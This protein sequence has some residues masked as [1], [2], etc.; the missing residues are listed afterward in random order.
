MLQA[1]LIV[2]GVLTVSQHHQIGHYVHD[3]VLD[4]RYFQNG[5]AGCEQWED[6]HKPICEDYASRRPGR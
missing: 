6:R 1:F 4:Y 3:R 2:V 5:P